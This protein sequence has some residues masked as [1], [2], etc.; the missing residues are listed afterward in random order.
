MSRSGDMQTGVFAPRHY[1][2]VLEAIIKAIPVAM[3]DYLARLE[4]SSNLTFHDEPMLQDIS[5]AVGSRMARFQNPVISERYRSST[6]PSRS[7]GSTSFAE[8]SASAATRAEKYFIENEPRRFPVK[9]SAASKAF[10]P[11]H[12]Q[13]VAQ[14]T[15]GVQ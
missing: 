8:G 11:L 3:M 10:D 4:R 12:V 6:F 14:N 9:E 15:I 5:L 2:E 1:F 7:I 13:R